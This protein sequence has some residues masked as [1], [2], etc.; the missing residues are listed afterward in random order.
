MDLR[1]GPEQNPV[2][3][4]VTTGEINSGSGVT[5]RRFFQVTGALAGGTL[6]LDACRRSP[7]NNIEMGKG[8]TGLLNYL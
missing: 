4:G 8:D 7:S 3:G 5:R 1:N 6:L 2:Q